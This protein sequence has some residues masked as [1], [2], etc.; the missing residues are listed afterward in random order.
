MGSVYKAEYSV[1][2]VIH[3]ECYGHSNKRMINFTWMGHTK[4]HRTRMIFKIFMSKI[5]VFY[6]SD[7]HRRKCVIHCQKG[8]Y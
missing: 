6:T 7:S 5:I 2:R 3:G 1:F 8:W 4:F